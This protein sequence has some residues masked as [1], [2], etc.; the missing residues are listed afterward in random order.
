MLSRVGP[1]PRRRTTPRTAR[2]LAGL[3]LVAGL[4]GGTS[5]CAYPGCTEPTLSAEPVVVDDPSSP[6]TLSVRLADDDGPISGREV[7]FFVLT[8]GGDATGVRAGQAETDADGWARITRE[9]GVSGPALPDETVHG[10]K[11]EFSVMGTV[12]G[13]TYCPTEVEAPITCRAGDSEGTCEPKP[14]PG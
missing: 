9:D 8:R 13:K 3:S 11:A 12:E 6:V 14:F 2:V 4:C 10:Y 5:A 7:T 1:R